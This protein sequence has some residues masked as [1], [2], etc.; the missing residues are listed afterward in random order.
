MLLRPKDKQALEDIFAS[1]PLEVEVW[2][3]GSRVLGTAHEGSDLDLVLRTK[4]LQPL[5]SDVF[6]V[7]LSKIRHSNVPIVVQVF[8]WAQLPANFH[9]QILNNYQILYTNIQQEDKV[10]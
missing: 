9:V 2:A 7:V 1:I 5:P 8:D 6:N 4:H 3:F 10:L